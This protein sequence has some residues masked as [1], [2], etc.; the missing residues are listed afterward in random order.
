M[1]DHKEEALRC[2]R[3]AVELVP[4]S[5]DGSG[6]PRLRADQAFVHAWT[7]DKDSALAEYTRLF[8][9]PVYSGE[10]NVH[11]MKHHPFFFPLQGDPRFEALLA[12]PK[13]NQPLF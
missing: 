6:G 7:G 8:G 3:K 1:L 11:V 12:D 13:N 4:E 9:I 10:V 5:M 2:A